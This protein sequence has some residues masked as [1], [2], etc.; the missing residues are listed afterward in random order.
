MIG[1]TLRGNGQNSAGEREE[2]LM[3]DHKPGRTRSE[4]I[5]LHSIDAL[6]LN[7][8]FD[9]DGRRW[10]C[11]EQARRAFASRI[12]RH[13]ANRVEKKRVSYTETATGESS[14]CAATTE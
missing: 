2:T 5:R 1:K 13:P 6:E 10:R 11:E 14:R 3:Q 7:Q 4:Q 8:T 12:G 9:T